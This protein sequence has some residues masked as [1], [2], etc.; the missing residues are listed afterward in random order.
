MTWDQ[1]IVLAALLMGSCAA[2]TCDR[3]LV[4]SVM[5]LNFG[6]TYALDEF[7]LAVG[8][9][10]IVSV[11]A[12]IWSRVRRNYVV[13]SIFL[14]MIV[15]YRFEQQLG[16]GALYDIV[17]LLACIQYVVMGGGGFGKLYGN[18]QFL[19]RRLCGFDPSYPV[20]RRS[21][22]SGGDRGNLGSN[23]KRGVPK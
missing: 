16:R 2:T 3:W 8:V 15:L 12:L 4:I 7:P 19:V 13:A 1:S 22:R 20:G 17:N 14:V 10:D 18:I 11:A 23:K 5:W 9:V 21:D 6:A